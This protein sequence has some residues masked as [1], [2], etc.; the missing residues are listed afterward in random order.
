MRKNSMTRSFQWGK[1]IEV[2]LPTGRELRSLF[3]ILGE[4][5]GN[6]A[7]ELSAIW[8]SGRDSAENVCDKKRKC[9]DCEPNQAEELEEMI[10]KEVGW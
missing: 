3:K 10:T 8:S 7:L 1:R 6:G 5:K 9:L 2:N 4:S